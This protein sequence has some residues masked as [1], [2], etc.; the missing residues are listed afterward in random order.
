MSIP[1]KT[2]LLAVALMLVPALGG[3]GGGGQ[4]ETD[5]AALTKAQFVRQADA[6]CLKVGARVGR[7]FK[8]RE[9]KQSLRPA[10]AKA[11]TEKEQ[12]EAITAMSLPAFRLEAKELGEL[13]PP[14]GDEEAVEAIVTGFEDGIAGLEENPDK[15]LTTG[16]ESPFFGV[17]GLARDYGLQVCGR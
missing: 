2:V 5:T 7:A 10:T 6:V 12:I 1:W 14:V 13:E 17:N 9:I 15:P 3:C 11:L 4:G 8:K 16:P